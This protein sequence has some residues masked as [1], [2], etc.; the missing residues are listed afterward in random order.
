MNE[1]TNSTI[2]T[3]STKSPCGALSA[4]A[5]LQ[6]T[7][8]LLHVEVVKFFKHVLKVKK[9]VK[10]STARSLTVENLLPQNVG[11]IIN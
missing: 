6:E 10:P 7:P 1:S 4:T 8:D 3:K 5:G 9:R 11:S 2:H